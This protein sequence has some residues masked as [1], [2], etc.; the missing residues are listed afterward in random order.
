M[1][2]KLSPEKRAR[3]L[4]SA[5]K[6][7]VADGV[8]NTSTNAI[9][10]DAGTATGTLFLY[11]PT[12]QDLIHELVL[13]I[14]KDQSVYI[15]SMLTP[16]LSVRETFF[17]IWNGSV[18]WF[19]ENPEAYQYIRQVRD[20]GLIA[21][22]VVRESEKFFVYYYDAIEAGFAEGCIKPYPIELIGSMLYQNIVAVMNLTGTVPDPAKQEEFIQSGFDIYWNGIK[23]DKK[24]K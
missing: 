14:G 23:T 20:S 19:L 4:S 13:K 1:A 3:F 21:E 22:E 7:F 8:K 16:S 11:F 5:L 18:R 24:D 15:K 12:K 9:A 2:R 6:L 10:K 17:T